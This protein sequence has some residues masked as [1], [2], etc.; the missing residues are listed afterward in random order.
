MRA[1]GRETGREGRRGMGLIGRDG[2]DR[3]VGREGRGRRRKQQG[4]DEG[5][6]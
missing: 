3:E 1:G 6:L 4:G 2:A 5:F